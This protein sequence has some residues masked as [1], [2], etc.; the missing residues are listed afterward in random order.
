ME[1]TGRT[2]PSELENNPAGQSADEI[3][4]SDGLANHFLAESWICGAAQLLFCV[5]L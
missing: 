3:Y 2:V 1:T 4:F 5:V